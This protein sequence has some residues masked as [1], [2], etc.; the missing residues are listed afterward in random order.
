MTNAE[1][2]SVGVCPHGNGKYRSV[3]LECSNA[4]LADRLEQAEGHL[5]ALRAI[6]DSQQVGAGS[7]RWILGDAV[8]QLHVAIKNATTP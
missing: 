8:R 1:A 7:S 3:C 5:A 6:V 2:R 4:D